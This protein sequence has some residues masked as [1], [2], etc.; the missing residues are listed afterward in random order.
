VWEALRI[1]CPDEPGPVLGGP[2][3]PEVDRAADP[4]RA[5]LRSANVLL[6]VL[7]A[8]RA[9]HLSAYG[10]GRRTTPEIDRIA[11]EGVRFVHAYTPAVYTL[12]AMSSVWTSEQPDRHHGSVSFA[13]RLPKDRL[14][15]AEVLGAQGV[16]SAGFVAN[17]VAGSVNGFDRG[18][19]EFHETFRTHGSDATAFME[20]V[21]AWLGRA[22]SRRFFLYLHFREP[23]F[24]YDP[25]PPFDTAFGPDGPIPKAVR[26]DSTWITDVNQGRRPL[27]PGELDHLVRLYDGNLASADA[28]LGRIRR[29]LEGRG[30]W[31]KTV[32]IVMADHGEGLG[33]HA[34]I[35]HNVQLYE[36][37]VHIPLI[38]R[39]PA[40]TGPAGV[41]RP[42][43]VDLR[44]IA[45]TVLDVFGLRGAGASAQSFEGRSLLPAAAGASAGRP[46]V[47]SRTVWDRPRYALG[48]EAYKFLYD[49]RTGEEQLVD[50]V[51]DPGEMKD[52][53]PAHPLLAAYY[54]ETL[55]DLIRTLGRS[56]T[57][58][59]GPPCM[60]RDQCDQLKA[61]G[62]LPANL[63]CPEPC[64]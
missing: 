29:E 39:F 23:H 54:R 14:T 42:G 63:P 19:D 4:L 40:G 1:Q 22:A 15:L 16:L 2:L 46:A 25:P 24:P 37:S 27:A 62:Y 31:E 7:D 45:P 58:E 56:A 41:T 59:G 5:A 61:L 33:E 52:A 49:T 43:L 44:D 35:G 48:D 51:Q 34:W 64:P 13:A 53:A 3:A 30:L 26:R 17:A 50:R 12:A 8:A 9:D 18:F 60:P 57:D 10:Y 38:V 36:A 6:V 21:P 11:A 47:L 55:H 20:E 28:Q 32:V